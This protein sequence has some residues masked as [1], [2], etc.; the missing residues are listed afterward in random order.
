MGAGSVS[1]TRLLLCV[2]IFTSCYLYSR[3]TRLALVVHLATR[4]LTQLLWLIT[5]A[6][7]IAK[8]RSL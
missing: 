3:G 8:V 2:C 1:C 5:R 7:F 4:S 6:K